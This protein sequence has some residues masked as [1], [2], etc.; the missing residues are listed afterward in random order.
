MAEDREKIDPE[1][2]RRSLLRL[3][4]LIQRLDEK[5]RLLEGAPRLLKLMGDLR[6]KIFD[7]EVRSTGRLLPKS[8]VPPEVLEAERIV[9]EAIRRQEE[10][11]EE[12]R[13]GWLPEEDEEDERS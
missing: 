8:E 3:A 1:E 5:G 4:A 13:G 10:A 11:E 7:Y 9:Q 2:L 12:W 6:S